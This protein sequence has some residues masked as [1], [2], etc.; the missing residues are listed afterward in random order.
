MAE[1]DLKNQSA[2]RKGNRGWEGGI[3]WGNVRK[4]GE[5]K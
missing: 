5:G 2:D 1:Y 4:R 3:W